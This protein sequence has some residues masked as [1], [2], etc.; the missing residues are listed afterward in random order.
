MTVKSVKVVNNPVF[1]VK[2]GKIPSRTL[3]YEFIVRDFNV[4]IERQGN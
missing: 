2:M 1:C 4:Q 3:N